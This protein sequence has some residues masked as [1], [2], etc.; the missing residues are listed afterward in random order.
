MAKE[1]EEGFLEDTR[2]V[3]DVVMG[4]APDKHGTSDEVGCGDGCTEDTSLSSSDVA[5]LTSTPSRGIT[6]DRDIVWRD[7]SS[8]ILSARWRRWIYVKSCPSQR[9]AVWQN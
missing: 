7:M 1:Q 2:W 3:N 8:R 4:D 9:S 5:L 6:I